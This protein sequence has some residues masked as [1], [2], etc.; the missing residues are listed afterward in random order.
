[1]HVGNAQLVVLG[2]GLLDVVDRDLAVLHGL[3][4]EV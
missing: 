4:V 2:D 1:M 3:S